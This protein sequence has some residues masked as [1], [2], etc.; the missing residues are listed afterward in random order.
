[1][2]VERNKSKLPRV[3]RLKTGFAALIDGFVVIAS[4]GELYSSCQLETVSKATKKYFEK[5]IEKSKH[6]QE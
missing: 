1:M 6:K 2:K 3:D 4:M 5:E